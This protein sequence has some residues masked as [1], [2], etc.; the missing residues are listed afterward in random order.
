MKLKMLFYGSIL[1]MGI[2][3]AACSQQVKKSTAEATTETA[4][5]IPAEK[6]N[7]AESK[8]IWNGTSVG[9]YTHIGTV[10]F[11]EAVLQVEDGKITGG[12]FT[13]DLTSMVATDE[14]FNPEEGYTKEKLIGHLSSPDFF[15]V[16][17]FPTAR[18]V[19]TG[20]E[21]NVATGTM[22]IR[23]IS[24]EERV[25]NISVI[26]ENGKTKI[27]GDLIFKRKNY[28]VSWDYAAKDML[29][30]NEVELKIELVGA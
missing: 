19:I 26:E 13:V 9:M 29:L 21:K 16:A 8:V 18:F 20:V 6:I 4:T 14:N 11:T 5:Q 3:M 27:T 17:N 1:M 15:D 23:G 22:T 30:K 25:E 2:I 28:N 10:N 24:N 7:L 12:S